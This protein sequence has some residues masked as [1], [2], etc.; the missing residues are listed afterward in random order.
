[1]NLLLQFKGKVLEKVVAICSPN[2]D[3]NIFRSTSLAS[4]VNMASWK[5]PKLEIWLSK[6]FLKI[7]ECSYP[8]SITSEMESQ[9]PD[10]D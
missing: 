3:L 5:K 4:L 2:V 1:M 10:E 8:D 7:K 9:L 6:S